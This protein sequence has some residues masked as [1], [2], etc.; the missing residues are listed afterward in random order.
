VDSFHA[1]TDRT[2]DKDRASVATMLNALDGVWTPHGLITMM[3]T[4][5]RDALD[6]ALIRAGRVDVE[7]KLDVL[8]EEQA[9]RL[10]ERLLPG[11]LTNAVEFVGK[12]PSELI[13][14]MLTNMFIGDPPGT[15]D[16]ILDFST[17][18]TGCLFFVPSIDLLEGLADALQTD[19]EPAPAS[20]PDVAP[21]DGSLGIGSLREQ[22]G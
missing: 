11:G 6:P 22:S 15:T 17:A 16:R 9:V 1:A 13:E 21:S 18:L 2:D 4:N 12:A 7:E 5:N 3:T 10:A 19:A 20:A 14:H 8:E